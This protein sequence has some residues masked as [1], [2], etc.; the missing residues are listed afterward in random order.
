MPDIII[1]GPDGNSY[2]FPEGTSREV[3]RTAMQ[4]RFPPPTPQA[5]RRNEE[6]AFRQRAADTFK[7]AVSG[8][9]RG[10]KPVADIARAV[11]P[12][13]YVGDALF[14]TEGRDAM[15]QRLAA[16][17]QQQQRAQPNFF[18]GGKIAGEIAGTVPVTAVGGAMLAGG[19]RLLGTVMPRAG[20]VVQ[21]I[22]EAAQRGGIGSGRTAAETAKLSLGRR[23]AGLAERTAG[24]AIAGGGGA[25]LT[26]QDVGT[27][28]AFGAAAPLAVAGVGSGAGKL[29]DMFRADKVRA[30][31][32]FRQ[33][34]GTDLEAARQVFANLP[35]SDQ[36]LARK[37]LVDEGIEPDAFMALGANMEGLR[38]TQTR[39]VNEAETAAARQRLTGAAGVAGEG[40]VTDVRAATREGR[41]K[42]SRAMT[43]AREKAFAEI[44]DVNDAEVLAEQANRRAREAAD[45]AAQQQDDARRFTGAASFFEDSPMFVRG[46]DAATDRA[47]VA[48][49]EAAAQRATASQMEDYVYQAAAQGVEPSRGAPLVAALRNMAAQPGTR[50]DDL[51]R[52]TLNTIANK[53]ARAMDENGMVNPYDMYQIR[54]TG[55]SDIIG[56]LQSKITAGN[57]PRSGNAQRTSQLAGEVETLI[58]DTLGPK[59]KSYLD[60]SAKGYAVVNRRELA[61]EAL[62]RFDPKNPQPFLDLVGRNDPDTVARIMQGGP[63]MEDISNVFAADPQRLAAL[64]N[65]QNLLVNRNRM[66]TLA[67]SGAAEAADIMN[68][69]TPSKLRSAAR[70]AMAGAPSGR[71]ALE[72]AENLV[73]NFMRPEISARLAEG[74]MP[75]P[76]ANA[77][78]NT[79]STPLK[80]DAALSQLSPGMR[81]AIAQLLRGGTMNNQ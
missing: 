6:E 73:G 48:A 74:F 7:A 14:G 28:A 46:A 25:A 50:V 44:T 66:D 36:R 49:Q 21:R 70:V 53:I 78:L 34:L 61:G 62:R 4:R 60:R 10:L 15:E 2:A 27:G 29:I 65:A 63:K 57:V 9:E 58:D 3:M 54:K 64:T 31:R 76:N 20:G 80:I 59:F 40:T 68:I 56:E 13:S 43:P 72:G 38:S 18:T 8:F 55:V 26:D 1:E 41:A 37:V 67:R 33:A 69:E 24:G 11:N 47:A 39:L 22:G 51:Q 32:L 79:Y 5:K 71:I 23:A 81:N 45:E 17:A 35:P 75:G 30:A 42:V 19:G 77:L 12:L 16:F 52:D